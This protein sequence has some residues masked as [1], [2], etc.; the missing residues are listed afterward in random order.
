MTKHPFS[1]AVEPDWWEYRVAMTW[2][3]TRNCNNRCPYCRVR[4]PDDIEPDPEEMREVGSWL[5]DEL[6]QCRIGFTG[7]EPSLYLDSIAEIGRY[8]YLVVNT[9]LSAPIEEFERLDPDK[10]L[11]FVSYHPYHMEVYELLGKVDALNRCG[12]RVPMVSIVAYPPIFDRVIA[13]RDLLREHGQKVFVAPYN[14]VMYGERYPYA[15]DKRQKEILVIVEDDMHDTKR[16]VRCHAGH[17][18]AFIDRTGVIYRCNNPGSREL[19]NIHDK[20]IVMDSEPQPCES[21]QCICWTLQRLHEY[22]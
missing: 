16:V 5:Y 17:N 15:Y 20:I 10:C 7:G 14:G 1:N 4:R 22:E 18:Y 2:M 3:L 8:H 12:Y 11:L 9:N 19:G 21:D 6:G 13:M